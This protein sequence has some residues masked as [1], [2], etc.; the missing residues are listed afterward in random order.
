MYNRD[1]NE[2]HTAQDHEKKE[3]RFGDVL[4]VGLLLLILFAELAF[5]CSGFPWGI[6]PG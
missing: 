3:W 1:A 2:G 4:L 6:W 5:V